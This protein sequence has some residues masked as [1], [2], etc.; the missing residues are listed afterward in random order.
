VPEVRERLLAVL[1][2]VASSPEMAALFREFAMSALVRRVAAGLP[3]PDAELRVEM[4]MAQIVGLAMARYVIGFE[5]VASVDSEALV[6]FLGPVLQGY[7][8]PDG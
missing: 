5:P 2:S 3:G 1:R 6:G 4:A 7:L 8:R